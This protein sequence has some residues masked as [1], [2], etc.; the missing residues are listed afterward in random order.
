MPLECD[1]SG[2]PKG[3]T[4]RVEWRPRAS[5]TAS[6]LPEDMQKAAADR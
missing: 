2:G 4:A 1:M 5:L 3:E 6:H